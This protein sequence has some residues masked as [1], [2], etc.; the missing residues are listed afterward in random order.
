MSILIHP[1][2]EVGTSWGPSLCSRLL[3]SCWRRAT[4]VRTTRRQLFGSFGWNAARCFQDLI[5]CLYDIRCIAAD[6]C[7][8][9]MLAD[10]RNIFSEWAWCRLELRTP[11]TYLSELYLFPLCV[12]VPDW[13]HLTAN[14]LKT[15]LATV[16]SWPPVLEHLRDLCNFLRVADYRTGHNVVAE[17]PDHLQTALCHRSVA[18]VAGSL[19]GCLQGQI[20]VDL[21]RDFLTRVLCAALLPNLGSRLPVPR[22]AALEGRQRTLQQV[23]SAACRGACSRRPIVHMVVRCGV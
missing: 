3:V 5:S 16:S 7:V 2:R 22:G 12:H 4:P 10:M 1:R 6:F 9:S 17:S 19:C 14:S 21:D 18:R 20:T 11:D 15:A 13:G 8:E 23:G